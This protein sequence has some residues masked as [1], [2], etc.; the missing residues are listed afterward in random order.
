MHFT[1]SIELPGAHSLTIVASVWQ[2]VHAL[3]ATPF[4]KYPAL[5]VHTTVSTVLPTGH[6]FVLVESGEHCLH[7]W[8]RFPSKKVP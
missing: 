3:H 1:L 2:E 6:S 8:Q 7:E 4:P 5:H